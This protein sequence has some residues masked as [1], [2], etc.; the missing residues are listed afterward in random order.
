MTSYNKV[1]GTHAAEHPYLLRQVLRGDLGF[2]GLLMS[3]WSG[4]YSSS[5]AIK[6]GLD[7]EMPGPA[8][9]RGVCVERGIVSGKLRPEEVD[10][11]VDRVGVVASSL[12]SADQQVLAYVQKAQASGIPFEAEEKS[13]DTP[14]V[15]ALLREAAESGVVLLK[16]DDKV[17]PLA[18]K[19]GMTIAVIGPNANFAAYSGGGSANLNPTY[20]VT[21]LQAI[22][23]AAEEFGGSVK[24]AVGA[25]GAKW[26]PLLNPFTIAPDGQVGDGPG[27]ICDFYDQ[28]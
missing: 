10:E 11:C 21:P 8:F 1:N 3:D 22:Q 27:V 23:Q 19:Q 15:R 2:K 4:T 16:N 13:E 9:M 24:Y 18:P 6:A 25:D 5:E 26:L 17:L 7:L 28:K 20:T 14:A 12:S